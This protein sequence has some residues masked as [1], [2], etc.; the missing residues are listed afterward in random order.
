MICSLAVLKGVWY[1]GRRLVISLALSKK[2]LFQMQEKSRKKDVEEE[3]AKRDKRNLYLAHEGGRNVIKS[4]S[5]CLSELNPT[6][7]M[8][9]T[10]AAKGLSKADLAKRMKSYQQRKK[11]LKNPYFFISKTRYNASPMFL[12][13]SAFTLRNVYSWLNF[14]HSLTYG[15]AVIFQVLT[16]PVLSYIGSPCIVL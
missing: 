11:T 13:P 8:P 3:E 12:T 1:D 5:V 4:I 2:E 14:H 6:V 7:I 16:A 10:E 15:I 9:G